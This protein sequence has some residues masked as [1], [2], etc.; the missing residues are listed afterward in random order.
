VNVTTSGFFTDIGEEAR[1]F[2][3]HCCF[4]DESKNEEEE[5]EGRVYVNPFRI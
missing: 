2:G 4:F 5:E 1:S 3:R